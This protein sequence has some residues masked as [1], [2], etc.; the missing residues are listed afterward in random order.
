MNELALT[1]ISLLLF[2]LAGLGS[3]GLIVHKRTSKSPEPEPAPQRANRCYTPRR[4]H[5]ERAAEQKLILAGLL[6]GIEPVLIARCLKHS[7]AY[8]AR[9]VATV[10]RLNQ[11]RLEPIHESREQ[12]TTHPAP[13]Q[14]RMANA[15]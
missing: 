15:T 11:H 1:G 4:T 10:K 5:A 13:T 7:P 2:V 9:L 6:A 12:A 8:N 14:A 3:I